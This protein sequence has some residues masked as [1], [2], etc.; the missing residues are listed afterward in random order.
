M[1]AYFPLPSSGDHN[2][3]KHVV[4]YRPITSVPSSSAN[5]YPMKSDFRTMPSLTSFRSPDV[6]LYPVTTSQPQYSETSFNQGNPYN[7]DTLRSSPRSGGL[8]SSSAKQGPPRKP[9]VSNRQA[10]LPPGKPRIPYQYK[11][12]AN[13]HDPNRR[14]PFQTAYEKLVPESGTLYTCTSPGEN[15]D[16]EDGNTTTSGSYTISSDNLNDS[17]IS[18]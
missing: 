10:T 7:S 11:E 17:F 8:H 3:P 2:S 9:V 12:D 4:E 1:I 18:A 14:S 6:R 16:E 5:R 15:V 13:H